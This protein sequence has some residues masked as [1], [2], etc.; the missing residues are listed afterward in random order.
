[1][2]LPISPP[3]Q[4]RQLVAWSA[5]LATPDPEECATQ[6]ANLRRTRRRSSVRNLGPLP[7]RAHDAVV[8]ID[9]AHVGG[10]SV[11]FGK[12]D[13]VYYDRYSENLSLN[14]RS[15]QYSAKLTIL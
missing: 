6:R 10:P 11:C 2:R 7:G 4:N 1:M 15:L 9:L 3:G 12:R 5:D 13:G 8:N 14:G